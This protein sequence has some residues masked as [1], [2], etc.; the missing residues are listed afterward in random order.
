MLLLLFF[1]VVAACVRRAVIAWKGALKT[2]EKRA[3]L[4]LVFAV[5]CLLTRKD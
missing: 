5:A 3:C 4:L 2:K 1:Q